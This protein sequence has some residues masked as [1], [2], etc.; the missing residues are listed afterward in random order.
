MQEELVYRIALSFNTALTSIVAE[1]PDSNQF[2][3][4]LPK[5]FQGKNILTYS[6]RQWRLGGCMLR[7]ES[8]HKRIINEW[9]VVQAGVYLAEIE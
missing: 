1:L 2:R 8:W 6:L 9:T 7:N 5:R 3:N 4:Y